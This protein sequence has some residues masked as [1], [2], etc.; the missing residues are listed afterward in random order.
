MS[1]ERK[2]H[3]AEGD[4]A[5]VV[6]QDNHGQGPNQHCLATRSL[7]SKEPGA[8]ALQN[9][10]KAMAG[11]PITTTYDQANSGSVLVCGRDIKSAGVGRLGYC[12]QFDALFEDLT[13]SEHLVYFGGA[14]N[15]QAASTSTDLP[16]DF[17]AEP[18][19]PGFYDYYAESLKGDTTQEEYTLT[20]CMPFAFG[21]A[22]TAS[23]WQL[24]TASRG[25]A[26]Q[27]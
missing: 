22:S 8:S 27:P 11:T 26:A 10:I 12:P 19:P 16:S 6:S 20:L 2:S 4:N 15:D 5:H 18:R 23:A 7:Q 1:D 13:V 3:D 17:P 14:N 9:E 25:P 24:L 21:R